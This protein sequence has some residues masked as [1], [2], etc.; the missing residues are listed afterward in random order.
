MQGQM[1]SIKRAYLGRG[2]KLIGY[3]H[4]LFPIGNKNVFSSQHSVNF[5]LSPVFWISIHND[6]IVPF[7]ITLHK[8]WS[9][10]L[11]ISPVNVI[12]SEGNCGFRHIYWRNPQRKTSFFVQCNYENEI[13][14]VR[15]TIFRTA[16]N[17]IK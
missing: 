5:I 10:P 8:K 14:Q 3:T 17:F 11:R 16:Q 9:F 1:R 2:C 15:I 6:R 12:K 13:I 7:Q 4:Y